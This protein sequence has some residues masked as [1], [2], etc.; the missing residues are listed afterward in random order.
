MLDAL[1]RDNADNPWPLRIGVGLHFGA[2]VAG[3]VG[4]SRRKE[5]TV[6]GDTVNCAARIEALNKDFG[7]QFLI[8][9]AI[10]R[11]AGPDV[12]DA[13]SVGDVLIRGYE[14]PMRCGGSASPRMRP[15]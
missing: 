3:N 14:T 4:S 15:D 1:E 2:V 13:T 5:Y 6:I 11:A 8:S 10:H 7:S 12:V 9:D